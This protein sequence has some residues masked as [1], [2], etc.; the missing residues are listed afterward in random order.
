MRGSRK[1]F[2]LLLALAGT[3]CLAGQ[4][5]ITQ[6]AADRYFPGLKSEEVSILKAGTPL[7]RMSA[8]PRA[9]ALRADDPAAREISERF[10]HLG[11]NYFAEFMFTLPAT[12]GALDRLEAFLGDPRHFVGIPYYSTRQATT[13]DL[14]DKMDII[15]KEGAAGESRVRVRQHMEPFGDYAA[16]YE[17]RRAPT[18]LFFS[19]QNTEPLIYS[20]RDLRVAGPGDLGW[21]LLVREAEG[22]IWFYGA[23]GVKAFDLF[24]VF[25]S[26]LEASFMGR[27]EAFFTA[28]MKAL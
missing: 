12:A 4:G 1:S 22:R 2:G 11:P 9:L 3:F 26:R 25:R 13:Y 7:V 28:A 18:S 14:F 16:L 20:Y 6:A 10:G 23:G 27:I 21:M 5:A 17:S 19:F 8:N 24:G 15:E